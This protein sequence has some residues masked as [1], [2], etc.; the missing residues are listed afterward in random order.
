MNSLKFNIKYSSIL[1][2]KKNYFILKCFDNILENASRCVGKSLKLI[3][4]KN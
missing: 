1:S 3:N 4:L 2:L